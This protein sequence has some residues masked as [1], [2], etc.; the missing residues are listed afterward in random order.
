M[1]DK[2]ITGKIARERIRMME[3]PRPPD[4]IIEGFRALGDAPVLS[5]TCWTSLASPVL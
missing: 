4:G 1:A 2:K 5:R 3:T